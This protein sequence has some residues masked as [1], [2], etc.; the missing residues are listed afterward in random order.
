MLL[1]SHAPG[2]SH[3]ECASVF[4]FRFSIWIMSSIK[5]LIKY[6]SQDRPY[7]RCLL[8]KIALL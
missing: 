3:G 6:V 2:G 5:C 7:D 1:L 4:R 8:P